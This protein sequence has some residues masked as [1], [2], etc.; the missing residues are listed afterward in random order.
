M[1]IGMLADTYKPYISGVTNCIALNKRV[2]ESG[3]HQVFVFTLGN[4][5]YEDNELYIV[6]SPAIPLLNTGFSLSFR[7]SRAA[8]RQ[9]ASMDIAHVH[10]P[11]I[12]G[13]LAIRYCRPRGLP[14]VFTNH[15]R[16]DLYAQAYLPLVPG[17]LSETFLHAYMP[18]FCANCDLVIAPSAGLVKVLRS[19]GVETPIEVVPNGIETASFVNAAP[20]PRSALGLAEG[21]RVL[22]YV[23]RVGPEKNLAF[24]LRAF[25][26]AQAMVD[27]LHLVIVG[28]GPELDNL[29]DRA[30]RVGLGDCVH[31]TGWV[32]YESVPGWLGL[33]DA[34][35]T[36]STTEVHPLSAIEAVAA[37]LPL[38]GIASPGIE[39]TIR[40]GQNGFLCPNDLAVF[41]QRL[42]QLMSD[43]ALR[44]RMAAEARAITGHYDIQR[45]AAIMQRHYERL[46]EA[47][48]RPLVEAALPGESGSLIP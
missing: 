1:R 6:R 9:L 30:G 14:I 4:E 38:V 45:T 34:F 10:H 19:F 29:R 42:V 44:E 18:D 27:H 17:S 41:T 24:L 20:R 25:T 39:D 21:D 7:Y 37:G 13:R 23:G 28:S 2:L 8:Q 47:R 43:A 26:A 40:D 33:A 48:A 46:I 3:G 22:I 35:V 31:F 11:F 12:S 5:G 16:Y 32:P 36:A 15:T